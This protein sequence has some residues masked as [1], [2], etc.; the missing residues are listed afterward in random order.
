MITYGEIKR[1]LPIDEMAGV[2]GFVGVVAV[3]EIQF[4]ISGAIITQRLTSPGIWNVDDES[5]SEY[6]DDL[7]ADEKATLAEML[8]QMNATPSEEWVM[9]TDFTG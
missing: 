1:E 5:S 3:T 6:L 2:E 7:Y 8:Q 4:R 9:P